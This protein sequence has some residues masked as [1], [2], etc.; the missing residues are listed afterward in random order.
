MMRK[1]LYLILALLFLLEGCSSTEYFNPPGLKDFVNEAKT[2]YDYLTNISCSA[3]IPS[4]LEY[5]ISLKEYRSLNEMEPFLSELQAYVTSDEVLKWFSQQSL[6]ATI[7]EKGSY[8]NIVI[9]YHPK[10]SDGFS[11]IAQNDTGYTE[12]RTFLIDK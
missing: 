3:S 6:T 2:S 7:I 10:N 11:L 12:W 1:V 4:G 9:M 5:T 8:Y